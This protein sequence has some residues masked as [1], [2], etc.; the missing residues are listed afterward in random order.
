VIDVP[1][2]LDRLNGLPVVGRLHDFVGLDLLL[3]QEKFASAY[4]TKVWTAAGSGRRP[5]VDKLDSK[6]LVDA[7]AVVA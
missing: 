1:A 5:V 7:L 4:V 3:S 6:P 2:T